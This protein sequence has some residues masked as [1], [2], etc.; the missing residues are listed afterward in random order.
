MFRK[1]LSDYLSFTRKERKGIF[2]LLALIFFFTLLPFLFPYFIS[3][4]AP[5]HSAFEKDI[6]TLK[7]K[8]AD[9]DRKFVQRNY[10]EKN[11]PRYYPPNEKK[12]YNKQPA[13]ELFYFD[14]NTLSAAGWKKLGVRDRTIN[15]IQHYLSKGGKFHQ[16]EDIGKICRAFKFLPFGIG[17]RDFP[18]YSNIRQ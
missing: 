7:I 13:G 11:Y 1:F 10:Y 2:V 5:N 6:A 18:M 16:P 12:Y 4:K 15:T 9:S 14:P 8:Q 17:R 3:H